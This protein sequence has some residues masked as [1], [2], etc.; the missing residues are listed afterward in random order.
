MP[1][2][3]RPLNVYAPAG[4]RKGKIEERVRRGEIGALSDVPAPT[5]VPGLGERIA[6]AGSI[7]EKLL[8]DAERKKRASAPPIKD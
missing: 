2:K 5:P 8:K 1:D 4:V 3:V 6:P 7:E